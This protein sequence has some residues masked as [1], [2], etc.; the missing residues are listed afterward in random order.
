MEKIKKGICAEA[1]IKANIKT[2][3][4]NG[5]Y[6]NDSE[7]IKAL[8]KYARTGDEKL[9]APL[10][11]KGIISQHKEKHN[12]IV[13]AGRSVLARLL[14]GDTTYSGQINYGALGTGTPNVVNG[15][16][17]LVTEVFRKGYA[18]HAQ[19]DNVA[20]IDFVYAANDCNGTY[21][22]FGNVIDGSGSANTG[23]LFSYIAT[24]GWSK[25]ALQTLFVSCEYTL[26]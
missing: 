9:I 22:E 5:D 23:Q 14:V 20:Y 2:F 12:I 4:L 26:T 1:K 25:T 13:T 19:G 8:R 15:R 3:V 21:S 16:T 10:L 18:S 17:Q 24:G 6:K 7:V 11:K